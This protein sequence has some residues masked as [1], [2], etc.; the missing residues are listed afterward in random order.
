MIECLIYFI[1]TYQTIF[2]GLLG[3]SGVIIT[4]LANAKIQRIQY[5]RSLGHEARSLRVALKSE[6]IA[7]RDAYK[8]RIDQF[9]EDG[10]FK[11]AL[12]PNKSIDKIFN[13]L[14]TKIGVLTEPEVEKVLRAYALMSELPYRVRILVGTDNVG[15]YNDEFIRVNEEYQKAVQGIHEAVLPVIIEAISSIEYELQKA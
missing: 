15:G 8:N 10:E 13:E 11:T 3:F 5:E 7:S 14:L 9:K 1:K 2:V 12:I 4:M 6:L